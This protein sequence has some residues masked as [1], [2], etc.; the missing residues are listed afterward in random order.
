LILLDEGD[1]L[2]NLGVG[3]PRRVHRFVSRKRARDG[4]DAVRVVV[5]TGTLSRKS[6]MGYW[7]FLIW[8]LGDLAPVP[9]LRADATSSCKSRRCRKRSP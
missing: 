6:I 2:S 8:A 3:A 4:F 5:L 1:E 7:H 9:L